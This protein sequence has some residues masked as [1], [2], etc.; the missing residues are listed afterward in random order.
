MEM[1]HIQ[2]IKEILKNIHYIT[3]ATVCDDGS[4]WNSPVSASFDTDLNFYWGSS[5][6][7]I[8]SKNISRDSRVFV[9]IYD[10]TAPEGTGEG[11]YMSGEA[12]ELGPEEHNP[13]VTK[14]K[15][16]P[17]KFWINDVTLD[18]FGKYLNDVRIEINKENLI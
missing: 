12:T 9:V 18:E 14:Y 3:I 4:P 11:V 7:N 10:S 17:S 16:S 15:F 2:S 1:R 6:E 13:S 5:R 8:H